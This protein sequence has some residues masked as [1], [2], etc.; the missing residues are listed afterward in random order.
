MRLIE[1]VTE[2]ET[3]DETVEVVRQVARRMRKETDHRAQRFQ[4]LPRADLGSRSD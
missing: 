4:D 1:I 3:S 2:N